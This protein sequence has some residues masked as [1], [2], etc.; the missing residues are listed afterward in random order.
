MTLGI[1]GARVL[2]H[3][4]AH[5]LG[6]LILFLGAIT[7]SGAGYSALR[8]AL[9]GTGAGW[10][11]ATLLASDAIGDV[12]PEEIDLTHAYGA[13]QDNRLHLKLHIHKQPQTQTPVPA[14][15]EF[16]LLGAD[17][18]EP[19][20][21]HRITASGDQ[22]R[23]RGTAQRIH[24]KNTTTNAQITV[25]LSNGQWQAQIPAQ[26]GDQIQLTP[27]NNNDEEGGSIYLQVQG[28]QQ[29][30]TLPPDP[31]N[32]P[33]V[34][35]QLNPQDA[36]TVY[37][38]TQFL[39]TNNPPIQV[40]VNP[41]T[42]KPKL[43]SLIVGKVLNRDNTPLSGVTVTI[44]D[45]DQY[46]HTLTRADGQLDMVVNGGQWFT[47]QY[48]KDGYLTRPKKSPGCL[49]R[50]RLLARRRHDPPRHQSQRHRPKR[51]ARQRQ[52]VDT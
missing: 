37:D 8:I 32:D 30:P 23:I 42:I 43:S 51:T 44:K 45:H 6:I 28:T 5:R 10:D 3:P 40:G 18:T 7:L 14:V 17:I 52:T 33:D 26:A 20:D 19:N 50:L 15:A 4:K 12:T 31:I 9:D 22:Q 46:G 27:I 16:R 2:R 25:A 38:S 24:I 48:T 1:L 36:Y 13:L 34:A 47:V 35:P 29:Q 49:A 21:Q 41:E 11:N 39:Y